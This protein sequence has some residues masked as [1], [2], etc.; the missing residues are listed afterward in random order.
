[1][2]AYE[3]SA[4]IAIKGCLTSMKGHIMYN[5]FILIYQYH[6]I[7]PHGKNIQR[8]HVKMSNCCIHKSLSS[9]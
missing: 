2:H 1:M 9:V 4:M 7:H 5:C 8:A 3:R 6:N